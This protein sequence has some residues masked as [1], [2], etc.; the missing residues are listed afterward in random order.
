[1]EDPVER[2]EPVINTGLAVDIARAVDNVRVDQTVL[3][4]IMEIVEMTRRTDLLELGVG[5]RG[6]MALHRVA[7]A[8]ALLNGR[9][10]C[11]PDDVNQ[12][13]LPALVHRVVPVGADWNGGSSRQVA[14][15][16]IREILA[17]VEIPI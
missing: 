8:H 1:M 2:I 17:Q 11:L 6:G 10:Y 5:P 4:Y 3:D 15:R 13:A 14:G 9:D 7:R 16:A 12:L